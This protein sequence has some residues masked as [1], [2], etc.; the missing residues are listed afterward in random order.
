MLKYNIFNIWNYNQFEKEDLL[1]YTGFIC[2]TIKSLAIRLLN[3]ALMLF[4]EHEISPWKLPLLQLEEGWSGTEWNHLAQVRD[5]WRALENAATKLFTVPW[6]S[7]TF[8]C[9]WAAGS[10]ARSGLRGV[11]LALILRSARTANWL[12]APCA[13]GAKVDSGINILSIQTKQEKEENMLRGLCP[14]AT[15]ACR[16]S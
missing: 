13:V 12:T 4:H 5:L 10:F 3:T 15:T 8:L 1:K 6:T 11:P 9:N 7:K 14:R 16:R 2:T